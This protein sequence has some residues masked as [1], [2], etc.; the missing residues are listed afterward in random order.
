MAIL[1]L[2]E[3]QAWV[4]R[5][6]DC[7]I[8]HIPERDEQGKQTGKR[9]RKMTIPIFKVEEAVVLGEITITTPAFTRLLEARVPVPYMSR[10]GQY[11]GGPT[12]TRTK[13]SILR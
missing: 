2:T 11:L 10:R 13:N 3:Q 8:V 5:E 1:Y 4:G 6:G 12:P 7:L 9:E